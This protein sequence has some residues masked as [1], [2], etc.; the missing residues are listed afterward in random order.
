MCSGQGGEIAGS[1]A[2]DMLAYAIGT[3]TKSAVTR[4]DNS[5]KTTMIRRWVERRTNQDYPQRPG[6]AIGRVFR[7]PCALQ[8][9][10]SARAVLR[11][12]VVPALYDRVAPG[13]A[14]GV[15]P[16]RRLVSRRSGCERC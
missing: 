14:L 10:P 5:A 7:E 16:L 3:C 8:L 9:P 1:A 13:A 12:H 2:A 15:I 4:C 6:A 11:E